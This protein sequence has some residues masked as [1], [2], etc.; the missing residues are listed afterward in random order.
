MEEQQE[1]CVW[2]LEVLCA[3]GRLYIYSL[4]G[5]DGVAVTRGGV[6]G[7]ERGSATPLNEIQVQI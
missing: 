4:E 3:G 6:E 7:G 2:L 1:G 5:E